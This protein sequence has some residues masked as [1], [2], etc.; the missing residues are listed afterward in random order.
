MLVVYAM[1]SVAFPGVLEGF[2]EALADL[3][4]VL[5]GFH[6]V[7]DDLR[8]VSRVSGSRGLQRISGVMVPET[9]PASQLCQ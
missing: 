7:P 2:K 1:V 9:K 5:R 8:G 6:G 3:K 4:A